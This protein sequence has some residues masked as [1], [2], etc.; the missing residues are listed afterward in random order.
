MLALERHMMKKLAFYGGLLALL[1]AGAA[2]AAGQFPGYPLA[3]TVSGFEYVP[4]DTGDVATRATFTGSIAGTALTTSTSQGVA[5]GQNLQGAGVAPG[6]IIVSGSGTSWVVSPSQTV[7]STAM[8]S[9]GG[10]VNPQTEV[11][12]TQQLRAYMLSAPIVTGNLNVAANPPAASS[13]GTSPTVDAGSSSNSGSFTTGTGSPST[14]T[15]TFATAF[16]TNAFCTI[17]PANAA[18][19]SVSA[20]VSTQSKTQFIVSQIPGTNNTKFHYTCMGN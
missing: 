2:N 6:T 5:V 18:A 20:Y 4:A 3:A 14:C 13:C 1:S 9:G 8:T 12:Q 16:A 17:S 7:T 11:I 10:G 19:V 15:I